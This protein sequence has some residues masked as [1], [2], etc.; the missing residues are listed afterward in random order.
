MKQKYS[1]EEIESY[2]LGEGS[3]V[4][5][6]AIG[7]SLIVDT[8]LHALAREVECDLIDDL[9]RG[10]LR[11]ARAEAWRGYLEQVGQLER[12]LV[13]RGLMAQTR[14]PRRLPW[15]L[16]SAAA[17]LLAA[18]AAWF[19]MGDN[20]K[21][22]PVLQARRVNLVLPRGVTRGSDSALRLELGADVG[23][24]ELQFEVAAEPASGYRM[25]LLD[26]S[27]REVLRRE[28]TGWPVSPL[29]VLLEATELPVGLVRLELLALDAAGGAAPVGFY[30]VTVAK[31]GR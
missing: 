8:E 13:A 3:D 19:V 6:A 20:A 7:E 9:A 11:G 31:V 1:R 23:R 18:G 27:G 16:A 12:L 5:R 22:E 30:E 10:D 4:E 2:L 21:V 28:G 25:R 15:W 26:A 14:P 24:V 29:R 17:V